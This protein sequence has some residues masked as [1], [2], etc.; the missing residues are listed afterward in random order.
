MD[1]RREPPRDLTLAIFQL[2][3]DTFLH[4]KCLRVFERE[5]LPTAF[6]AKN[7]GGF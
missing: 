4:F 6:Y 3:T 1:S 7:T 2:L 5:M